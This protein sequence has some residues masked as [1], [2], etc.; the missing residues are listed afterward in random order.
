MIRQSRYTPMSKPATICRFVIGLLLLPAAA[1]LCAAQDTKK[2]EYA[3]L[4]DSSG[5][6]RSQ[7]GAVLTLA[8]AVVHQVHDQGSVSI[9]RFHGEGIREASR[10]VP[11]S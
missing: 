11:R 5:S 9:Y 3:I 1:T 2:S 6:M 10:A 7:F 8:K 4:V